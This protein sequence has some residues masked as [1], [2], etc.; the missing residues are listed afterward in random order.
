MVVLFRFAICALE[1]AVRCCGDCTAV[2]LCGYLWIYVG[3]YVG[4]RRVHGFVGGVFVGGPW[5]E[6]WSGVNVAF[7]CRGGV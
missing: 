6:A 7:L 5:V 2:F 3:I 4:A 1:F